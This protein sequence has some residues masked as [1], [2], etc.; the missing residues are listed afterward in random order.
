[1]LSSTKEPALDERGDQGS[2]EISDDTNVSTLL[3]DGSPH[4]IPSK[5]GDE[6]DKSCRDPWEHHIREKRVRDATPS[7]HV[8]NGDYDVD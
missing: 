8:R 6:L 7:G 4:Q 2:A 1:M 3:L 5:E